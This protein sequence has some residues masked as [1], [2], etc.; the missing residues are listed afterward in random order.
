MEDRERGRAL[1]SVK[2]SISRL[3]ACKKKCGALQALTSEL[4]PIKAFA[5]RRDTEGRNYIAHCESSESCG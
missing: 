5:R 3:N 4:Q 1:L 2:C